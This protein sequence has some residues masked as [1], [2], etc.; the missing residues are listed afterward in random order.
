MNYR[1]NLKTAIPLLLLLIIGGCD[2]EDIISP[3][4][5]FSSDV[6]EANVGD[7]VT[8]TNC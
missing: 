8:F 3:K 5:W 4:A 6:T 2:K 7:P 1:K